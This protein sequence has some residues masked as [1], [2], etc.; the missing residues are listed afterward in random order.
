[1]TAEDEDVGTVRHRTNLVKRVY[2]A[3]ENNMQQQIFWV[4]PTPAQRANVA[5]LMFGPRAEPCTL[6]IY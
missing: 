1:M 2:T 6:Y 4:R 5:K 3:K